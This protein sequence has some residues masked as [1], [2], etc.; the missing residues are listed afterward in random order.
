MKYVLLKILFVFVFYLHAASAQSGGNNAMPEVFK[1]QP[2]IANQN[3]KTV[4]PIDIW[5]SKIFLQAEVNGKSYRFILDTGSPTILTKKVADA[6]ALEIQG[7]N[8]GKDANG[9]LVT[10]D[11]AVLQQ[12][13]IADVE[14]H[15]VP[16]FIFDP[17][18]LEAGQHI[19]DGGVIG[20]E[21][22]PLATWQI[23]FAN[24]ELVI[25][26]TVSRLEYISAAARA[27]L[28]VYAYPHTPIIEHEINGKFKDKAIFDTG[29]PELLHLNEKAAQE[30]KKRKLISSPVE[31]GIGTFGE[32]GGGRGEDQTYELL[33]IAEL[34]LGSL[35]FEDVDVWTRAEVPSLIGAKLFASHI[36]TLDYTKR[37]IYFHEYRKQDARS[38]GYG[39]K[40]YIKDRAV[41]VGFLIKA[42]KA[43]KA[44]IVLHDQLLEVNGKD[45]TQ[46]EAAHI[47]E[48]L[49]WLANLDALSEL[50]IKIKRGAKLKNLVLE[51]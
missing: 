43:H 5:A 10:M 28:E 31:R 44:G 30:L 27:R 47:Q 45:L 22:M 41:Y 25:T 9:N 29:S 51:L 15:N 42:S 33:N 14:F 20:S 40:P 36:V 38:A 35:K 2:R 12:L 46:I 49:S 34:S 32:S 39:F 26:D 6:L 7:Q 50:R 11:L 1:V 23:N 8:T 24:K 48:E 21:I 13:K 17:T 3:Y 4:V 19:L 18:G 16:V 37:L